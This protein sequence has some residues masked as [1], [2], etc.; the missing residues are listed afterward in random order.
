M[1][2][3]KSA[4]THPATSGDHAVPKRR[5][6][7]SLLRMWARAAARV[8]YRQVEVQ[9]M[10][11]LPPDGPVIL[12]INHTNALA[13]VALIV[14]KS[15]R[16]PHFLAAATW[17]KRRSARTLFELGG[18]LPLQRKGDVA[19]PFDNTRTFAACHR[20]LADDAL[21]AIFPEGVMHLEPTVRPLK[22]GAAR[23]GLGAA[24]QGCRGVVIVP[25]GLVYEDRGRFR[26]DV[27]LRFGRPIVMDEWIESYRNDAFSAVRSVTEQLGQ[28][29][30][31][32]T[33]PDPAGEQTKTG[34]RPS[35]AE[36]VML[37]PPA[38]VG[39][40]AHAPVLVAGVL[41]RRVRD[42]AWR[43]TVKGLAGTVLLPIVWTTE[44]VFLSRHYGL[45]RA[46]ELPAAGAMSGLATLAWL[47]RQRE[48]AA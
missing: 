11:A 38:A 19:G 5:L 46:S 36:L 15:P 43:A 9:G 47:D 22:T 48:L 28:E 3:M 37:T 41:A 35:V 29:L 2:Y 18:V 7:Y 16:F 21:L 24:D 40:L 27:E 4:S 42:E 45:R 1:P 39:M 30:D 14:A 31:R 17:W 26:S 33:R 12:A 6:S 10:E 44:V 13:D 23:I 32:V 8:F 20:A 25:L 34:G